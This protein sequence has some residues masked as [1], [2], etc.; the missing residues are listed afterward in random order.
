MKYGLDM[1]LEEINADEDCAGVVDRILP[2]LRQMV[3]QN[4]MARTLSLRKLAQYIGGAFPPEALEKVDQALQKIGAGKG[5]TDAEKRKIAQYLEIAEQDRWQS[6]SQGRSVYAYENVRIP[7][8]G[9]REQERTAIEPGKPFLD[10]KGRRI[11]AHGGC[12][13]RQDGIYYWIGEN[14][15]HTDGGKTSTI[16]T[17]GIRCYRSADMM[18]WEDLGLIIPP[19]LHDPD[20]CLFPDKRVDRPHLFRNEETNRYVVWVKLSGNDACFALFSSD[21]LTGPYRLERE[22][23][24]PFDLEVGDFDI[25]RDEDTGKRYLFL[26]SGQKGVVTLELTRDG[27]GAERCV[28]SSYAGLHA[29][30]TRE[31]IAVFER[32]GMKFMLTSDMTGYIPNQSDAAAAQRWTDSF[33]PVGDPFPD[34]ASL[35]SY[36]SQFTQV[37]RIPGAEPEYIA[38]CDRWVPDYPMEREKELMFRR[39]IASHYDPAHYS[40]TGGEQ[41]I[42]E[43]APGLETA[44]TSKADYVWLPIRFVQD[45]RSVRPVIDWTDRWVPEI[46]A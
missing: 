43:A 3:K 23:Y 5:R 7:S 4:P 17:W 19:V 34:D 29:P 2:G 32:E 20:S 30:F 11:Q 8:D 36:N 22:A 41:S 9:Q 25:A 42:F 33:Q 14:K 26:T 13:V 31:G 38:L 1:T 18:N 21:A 44:D 6:A 16:W 39:V 35:S 12:V 28:T 27:L 37:L 10:T 45:E 24:R 46:K 40:C 15:E